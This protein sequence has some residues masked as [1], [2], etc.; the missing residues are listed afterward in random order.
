MT[1]GNAQARCLALMVAASAALPLPAAAQF[2]GGRTALVER[3]RAE[4]VQF[5]DFFRF[6]FGDDRDRGFGTYSPSY[7]FN[8]PRPAQPLEA[9]KPPP[10]RKV[11]TQPSSLVLV[12]GDTFADWLAFGLEQTLADTPAIGVV[13]KIRPSSGLV[14]YDVRP[15]APDWSQAVKDMLA[16]EKPSAIVIMLGVNDRLPLRERAAPSNKASPQGQGMEK[17][18]PGNQGT[19]N[20]A[21][22]PNAPPAD[23]EQPAANAAEPQR[24]PPAGNYEFRTD[25]WAELYEKRIDD[26][27][28]AAKSKGVPIF[29]VG[30]PAIRGAKSTSDMNYLDELYRARAEKAGITYVDIWDGFIDEKGQFVMQGPDF[31]GQIRRLRTYDGVNF[32]NV[33]ADKLAHY[34]EHELRRVLTAPVVPVAL[35]GPEE[36]AP[37]KGN[38][39]PKVGPV[40]P[41]NAAV[42]GQPGELLGA[43]DHPGQHASDPVATQILNH[44]DAI[45][46]PPGRAD[47]FSWP[48]ADAGAADVAAPSAPPK[49]QGSEIAPKTDGKK[50]AETKNQSGPNAASAKNRGTRQAP[51]NGQ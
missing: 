36:Q 22:A 9:T 33:G 4:L 14:R 2:I 41:L 46:A 39:P 6:P 49:T 25:I 23:S 28:A 48:R 1:M 43:T 31:Q 21:P 35:P 17:T 30:L 34:V 18:T 37:A 8:P 5:R 32:T 40:V 15:D 50:S 10:P 27:I 16:T 45:A 38:A 26:M 11:E 42:G 44:G 47:N 51:E 3:P 12:I 29:W 24:H 19:A 7:P 20:A 13:R